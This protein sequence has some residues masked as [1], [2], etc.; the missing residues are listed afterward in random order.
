VGE[1][2]DLSELLDDFRDEGRAQVALLDAAA[3]ALERGQALAPA[4]RDALL[5]ALHTLKGNAGMLGM[6]PLQ[7][8][9]H[10]LEDV[11]KPWD[12]MPGSHAPASLGEAAAALRRAVDRAGTAGEGEAFA[13]LAAVPLSPPSPAAGPAA[14]EEATPVPAAPLPPAEAEDDTEAADLREETLR[15]PIGRL[16]ALLSRVGELASVVAALEQWAAAERP[17]LEAARLRRPLAERLETLVAAATAVRRSATELRTIPVG[18]LFARFVGVAREIARAQGKRVRVVLEGEETGVDKSTAD[19][20]AE[21]LLH[22]VRNAVDHGIEPPE[23][24]AAAGKEPEGTLLL[25]A[26]AEGEQVRIEVEDDGAGLDLAAARE[27][28]RERGLVAG[29]EDLSPAELA[30]LLFLPGFSTRERATGVSGRGVGLD[31]VR[32]AL[33]ALRGSVEVEPGEEGGTRFVLRLPLTLALLPALFFEAGGETF[34]VPAADV[35]ETMRTPPVAHVGP[36]ET[37]EVRGEAVPL[38]RL[39]RLFGWGERGEPRFVVLLRRGTRAAAVGAD[40]LLAQRAAAVRA[41]PA[42]LAGTRGVSGATVEAGG[43]VVLLLDA[44]QVM[45]LNVDHYR[46]GAGGG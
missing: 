16:D 31:A 27:R 43:K 40:R 45:E 9:V 2:F 21:P 22:L 26:V 35:E 42:G 10:A 15:V 12:G 13:A 46:G 14:W 20:L 36:A 29:D 19:A 3:A 41:L 30:E 39:S 24:R 18:R 32:A 28:A 11:L 37:V 44:A 38:V 7:D 34:A 25:R 17:A 6:R 23:R 1:S 33:A 8:F 5:R 4:A